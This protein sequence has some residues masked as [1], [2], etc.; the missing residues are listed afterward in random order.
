MIILPDQ[1]N[2]AGIRKRIESSHRPIPEVHDGD[3]ATVIVGRAW[4]RMH[5]NY[6]SASLAP[7]STNSL[8]MIILPDQVNGV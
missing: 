6:V 1:V 5:Q 3:I 8:G 7:S 2:G 4:R